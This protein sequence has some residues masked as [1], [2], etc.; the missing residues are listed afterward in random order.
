MSCILVFAFWRPI[1]F[2]F[3]FFHTESTT[4]SIGSSEP[5]VCGSVVT[6]CRKERS[7]D[8]GRVQERAVGNMVEI[9]YIVLE[10][11]KGTGGALHTAARVYKSFVT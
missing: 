2:S 1:A 11:Q 10:C 8:R 7:E 3:F 6:I 9:Q 4:V 5:V